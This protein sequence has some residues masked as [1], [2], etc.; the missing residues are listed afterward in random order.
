MGFKE[1]H[2][3][4][5]GFHG[6]GQALQSQGNGM[7]STYSMYFDGAANVQKAWKILEAQFPPT[8][9][10]YGGEHAL[11][12]WFSKMAKIIG[13]RVRYMLL[14]FYLFRGTVY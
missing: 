7:G 3:Y 9:C 6:V 4:C 11:A 13:I 5:S 1:F 12:L 2:L 10:L 14:F 8:P